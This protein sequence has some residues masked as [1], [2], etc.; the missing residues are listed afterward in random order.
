MRRTGLLNFK[1]PL[2]MQETVMSFHP[3]TRTGVAMRPVLQAGQGMDQARLSP[4]LRRWVL[5]TWLGCWM[6]WSA[7]ML[8]VLAR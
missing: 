6:G 1:G 7:A 2:A 3:M 4:T 8:L 5:R